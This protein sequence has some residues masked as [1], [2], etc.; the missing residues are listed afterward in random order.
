MTNQ[1]KYRPD[2]D[3]LRA[4]A[5]IFVVCFH[6]FPNIFKGGF[7][8]VDIFFVIS[9]YLITKIIFESL[10]AGVFSFQD[11]Y[12]RRIKRIF[13]ALSLVLFAVCLF[14]SLSLYV[15][16]YNHLK[17]HIAGGVFFLS[18]FLLWSESGYFD[19]SAETKPLLHLWSLGVEEQFYL[20]WPL[21]IFFCM[22]K[23][24]QVRFSDSSP[25][26]RFFFL[27]GFSY[28]RRC[29]RRIL[30]SCIS[31]LGVVKWGMFGCFCCAKQKRQ[32]L[33]WRGLFE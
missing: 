24:N 2:I 15:D 4:I 31:F 30:L 13:P 28:F 29:C 18:N 33:R 17:K 26:C 21:L 7:V 19:V 14:G 32:R 25:C 1:V 22:A 11:F 10:N 6:A 12:L 20:V 16:E 9:G 5:V 8:G 27:W 23:K 3:G